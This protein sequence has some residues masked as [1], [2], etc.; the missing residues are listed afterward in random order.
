VQTSGTANDYA[1]V[2]QGQ[3]KNI[4]LAAITQLGVGGNLPALVAQ[5][6]A[7]TAATNDYAAVNLGQLKAVAQPIY[8]AAIAAGYQGP[9]LVSGGYPWAGL[10]ASANDYAIA[11][12]GQVKAL[13]SFYQ[14]P[15]SLIAY[16]GYGQVSLSWTPAST[17]VPTTY[18]V[19]RGTASSSE[20]LLQAGVLGASYSDTSSSNGV[21][22]YYEV[23]A[24]TASGTT[25][26][27][28]E[29]E[30]VSEPQP[31][32]AP[33]GLA[34]VA[35]SSQVSLTWQSGGPADASYSIWRGVSSGGEETFV[36]NSTGYIDTAVTI[37]KTYY[38][39]VYAVSNAGVWSLQPSNE[40]SVTIP[41]APPAA[42]GALVASASTHGITVSW[43]AVSNAT[44]YNIYRKISAGSWP[45]SPLNPTPLTNTSYNDPN[46][47]DLTT[48]DYRV[49]AV[50]AGGSS[51][52]SSAVDA[53]PIETPTGVNGKAYECE[54]YLTW[55]AVSGIT[56]YNIYR[57]KTAGGEGN[58]PI[59]T[60]TT[61][62]YSDY[63]VA[64]NNTYYYK[65][66]AVNTTVNGSSSPSVEVSV[67]PY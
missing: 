67:T 48:Y 30:A 23:A 14:T 56:G 9:P 28:N 43:G 22:Y 40:I 46:L 44:G 13:F 63:N 60:V 33:T 36:S 65:I 17:G 8:D 57:G 29:V 42:P 26:C 31:P 61:D 35:T 39:W 37:G 54:A 45:S 11:N 15:T 66:V 50:N 49:T 41:I 62:C 51:A 24:V 47:A 2:N 10:T 52:P 6:S 27:S 12:I 5:L 4:A 25:G 1:A 18:N 55:S 32:P 16:P 53:T 58:T 34:G 19:Y 38:Y 7:T 3:L 59:A 20:T 64:A 21:A